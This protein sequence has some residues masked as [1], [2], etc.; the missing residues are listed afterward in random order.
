MPTAALQVVEGIMPLHIKAEQEVAYVRTARMRKTS[1]YNN[2]NFKPINYEDGTT[3]TKFHPAIFQLEGRIYLKGNSFQYPVSV[4]TW[5]A[6]R[7]KTKQA[8]PSVSSSV[9]LHLWKKTQRNTKGWR[10]LVP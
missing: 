5:T 1:N 8:A 6:Q 7:Q 4:F 10:N 3:S 9:C 2:I